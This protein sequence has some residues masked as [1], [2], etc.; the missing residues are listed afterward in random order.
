VQCAQEQGNV[1]DASSPGRCSDGSSEV[2]DCAG[3]DYIMED[4]CVLH[5]PTMPVVELL[6]LL[7][8]AGL[9]PA[10]CWLGGDMSCGVT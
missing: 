6:L 10:R 1:G 2:E 9:W 3:G 5:S 7:L 8:L 4:A